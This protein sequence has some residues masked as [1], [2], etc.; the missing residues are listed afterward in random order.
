MLL[1]SAQI[2]FYIILSS[3]VEG[4]VKK[5][6]K[7]EFHVFDWFPDLQNHIFFGKFNLE[8]VLK[9]FSG[10]NNSESPLFLD[11]LVVFHM[12]LKNQVS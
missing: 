5:K 12:V 4:H 1:L 6:F 10:T 11:F 7:S 2:N 8:P 9:S 3:Y